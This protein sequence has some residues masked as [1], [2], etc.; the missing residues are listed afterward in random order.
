MKK[1]VLVVSLL[2]FMVS[3]VGCSSEESGTNTEIETNTS[4]GISAEAK[5]DDG[6]YEIDY[7]DAA[8]FENAL[9]EGEEVNGA[10]VQF[11]VLEFKPDSAL[12]I[13]CWSGEHLNF[14]SET[15]PDVKKGDIV[16]GRVIEE[17]SKK[18]GSWKVPYEVIEI[19]PGVLV[20]EEVVSTDIEEGVIEE[21]VKPM[22]SETV[23]AVD[24]Y[25][26]GDEIDLGGVIFN[27]YK[28]DE[29]ENEIYLL[30]QNSIA[31]T[32][33][34][35]D[36]RPYDEQHN[37]EGSLVEGYVNR[38]VDDLEDK[39]IIIKESGI[40]DK[41][42][43]YELGFI[44]SD[45]LSGRPYRADEAMDFVKKENTYWVGGYCKYETMSWAYDY[46]KLDTESCEEEYGV[47]P[48]V[49]I[50]PSE[51]G[52][53]LK[54]VNP[55]LTIKEIVDSDC[56][57]ASEGGIENPYDRFYF[58]CENMTFTN[59]FESS[60][61]SDYSEFA[62]EFVDEKT[63]RLEGVMRW[64]EIP[65]ELTIVNENKLR[66]RFVDDAYNDGDYYLNKVVE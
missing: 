23:N 57:W 35:D 32:M 2:V 1:I 43:L 38:F 10:V 30:A 31:T 64:Y 63:I 15:E 62:M 59:I 24:D 9:N 61:L 22:E 44:H 50:E 5:E 33:F 36:E 42:D 54:T 55:A 8:S 37:Y 52:K 47:R 56:A 53:E 46:G 19:K 3:I 34:S 41:D 29:H 13:N 16:V 48:I 18:L 7:M 27:I 14:I 21:V 6:T 17:P 20:E 65:A 45:G 39:G 25:S 49:V 11:D 51:I 28:I 4:T 26:V 12:G 40:I 66:L 58:D 60:E